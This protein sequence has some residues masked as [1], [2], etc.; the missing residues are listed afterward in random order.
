MSQGSLVPDVVLSIDKLSCLKSMVEK[1]SLV[2]RRLAKATA[3]STLKQFAHMANLDILMACF[4][5]ETVK[6][7]LE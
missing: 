4:I 1:L 7:S 3:L 2:F 6:G 5:S